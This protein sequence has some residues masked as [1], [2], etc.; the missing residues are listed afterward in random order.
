MY[1]HNTTCVFKPQPQVTMIRKLLFHFVFVQVTC[2]HLTCNPDIEVIQGSYW[3]K[4]K[5]KSFTVTSVGSNIDF[6]AVITSFMS[7]GHNRNTLLSLHVRTSKS[8]RDIGFSHQCFCHDLLPKSLW[9][10]V[11]D[12]PLKLEHVDIWIHGVQYNTYT[13]MYAHT[14]THTHISTKYDPNC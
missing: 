2:H 13:Y 11:T 8:Q 6:T 1:T 14:Y 12:C 3:V 4:N 5:S 7:A 10:R 9:S